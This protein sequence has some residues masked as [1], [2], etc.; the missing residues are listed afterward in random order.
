MHGG[1][2]Q[3]VYA[4]GARADVDPANGFAATPTRPQREQVFH[5]VDVVELLWYGRAEAVAGQ[6]PAQVE[7][8]LQQGLQPAGVTERAQPARPAAKRRT[9]VS[10]MQAAGS[11]QLSVGRAAAPPSTRC[12]C[13][14]GRVR[15]SAAKSGCAVRYLAAVARVRAAAAVAAAAA[16]AAAAHRLRWCI[17][18]PLEGARR[19]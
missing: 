10:S 2:E 7:V 19:R 18:E 11:F 3:R 13:S 5:P 12:C 9:L 15:A 1:G 6:L 14:A 8:L 4:A 16:A 17:F